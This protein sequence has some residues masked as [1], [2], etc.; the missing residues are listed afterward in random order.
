MKWPAIETLREM[1]P[2]PAGY[3]FLEFEREHIA[4]L[5]SALKEWHPEIAAGVSS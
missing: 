3:G 4:P 5:I 2:L 1:I